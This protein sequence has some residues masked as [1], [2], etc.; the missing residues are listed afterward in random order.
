VQETGLTHALA[1]GY[2]I[3]RVNNIPWII[4]DGYHR[5]PSQFLSITQDEG[6]KSVYQV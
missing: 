2:R 3:A 6:T 4:L 5:S 1:S